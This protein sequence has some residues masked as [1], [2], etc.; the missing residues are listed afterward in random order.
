MEI[1]NKCTEVTFRLTGEDGVERVKGVDSFNYIGRILHRSEANWT[2]VLKNIQKARQ[3]WGS[4]GKLLRW[5]DVD[6]IVLEKFYRTVVEEVLLFGAETWV[7][8]T[9]MS[10]KL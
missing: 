8:M 2:A 10:Q 4:L 1:L 9:G 6:L 3:V 7:M 5:E